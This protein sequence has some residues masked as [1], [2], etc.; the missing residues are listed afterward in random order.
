MSGPASLLKC[1][2]GTC[3][4][5][6]Q[7]VLLLPRVD[8]LDWIQTRRPCGHLEEQHRLYE[9]ASEDKTFPRK[10]RALVFHLLFVSPCTSTGK[11]V[12]LL[13][14]LQARSGGDD[15]FDHGVPL[16]P[17]LAVACMCVLE[18]LG[19][20]VVEDRSSRTH[21]ASAPTTLVTRLWQRVKDG[22][23]ALLPFH[24]DM[25]SILDRCRGSS[26]VK[27]RSCSSSNL[28][29]NRYSTFSLT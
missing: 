20:L 25:L 17:F 19:L 22:L 12:K 11:I 6:E 5:C 8:P 28:G 7:R 29:S 16:L 15:G 3:I 24:L 23:A 14:D 10:D 18:L 21:I 27:D 1:C 4:P 9:I 13:C 2:K 26:G